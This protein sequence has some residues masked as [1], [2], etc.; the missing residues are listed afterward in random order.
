MVSERPGLSAP[1]RPAVH[2][3]G[4]SLLAK[5]PVQTLQLQRYARRFRGQVRSYSGPRNLAYTGMLNVKVVP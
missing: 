4:A 1:T 2:Y 3:V 5:G